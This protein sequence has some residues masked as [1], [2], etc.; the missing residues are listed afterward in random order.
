MTTA[1]G[2]VRF[3]RA[4]TGKFQKQ[5]YAERLPFGIVHV[6][7][8]YKSSNKIPLDPRACY[9]YG[10]HDG[11]K[12]WTALLAPNVYFAK[13]CHMNDVC[14]IE[15]NAGQNSSKENRSLRDRRSKKWSRVET[16]HHPCVIKTINHERTSKFIRS[17][18]DARFSKS[19]T[20]VISPS[21]FQNTF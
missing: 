15:T 4:G 7:V 12:F 16:R 9:G 8:P 10:L 20:C 2:C 1:S 13:P 19:N 21:G 6:N 14:P 3:L 5:I 11:R 18:S 17:W